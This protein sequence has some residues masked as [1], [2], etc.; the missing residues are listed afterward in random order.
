MQFIY[1]LLITIIVYYF[2][3]RLFENYST[4][5]DFDP[6]LVPVSSIVTLAKVAQKLVDGNGT[7]TNPGNLTV[8][9]NLT[10]NGSISLIGNTNKSWVLYNTK[11][12]GGG[13]FPDWLQLYNNGS[14]S[15]APQQVLQIIPT[16]TTT[17]IPSLNIWCNTTINGN[18][19]CGTITAK[20]T[21]ITGNLHVSG[22]I[23]ND[24]DV[25]FNG[26]VTTNSDRIMN[27]GAI[28]TKGKPITCGSITCGSITSSNDITTTGN[29]NGNGITSKGSVSFG[30]GNS[31]IDLKGNVTISG[32]LVANMLTIGDTTINQNQ[33]IKLLGF[34]NGTTE[35]Q[36]GHASDTNNRLKLYVS[37]GHLYAGGD[38]GDKNDNFPNW[39]KDG[40]ST[41]F[42]FVPM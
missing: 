23:I 41:H 15:G 24:A 5:E 4:Q 28:N 16:T 20:G 38:Y 25:S 37:G 32:G 29:V 1:I 30:S 36:I 2:V 42:K 26:N 8:T 10:T 9:G 17:G 33:L 27:C 3:T 35:F 22:T 6:S 11:T 12:Q 40:N 7:L 39:D 34:L 13:L 19:Q 21:D 31:N 18:I 14:A